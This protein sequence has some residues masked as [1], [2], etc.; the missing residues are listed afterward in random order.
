[1]LIRPGNTK[2]GEV[3]CFSLL[4]LETCPGSTEICRA[5]C[6]A[7]KRFFKMG[8]VRRAHRRNWEASQESDF[9]SKMIDEIR[10]MEL[11]LLR[12][13]V[14]GDF[15]DEEYV[16]KWIKIAKACPEVS[17]YTYTRSWREQELV[18][19][20]MQLSMVKN[21]TLW[22]S[23]D[24]ETDAID[25][26]PPVVPGIRVAYMQAEHGE[27]IPEY[28]DLVFRV[29]RDTIEK[30]VDGHMVCPAE[31]GIKPKTHCDQ[32]AM[33]WTDKPIPK[34]K[35]AKVLPVLS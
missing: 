16:R 27:L 5:S 14:A 7:T 3:P 29:K 32:C 11:E 19:A 1:M 18:P 31:N 2:L 12:V 13:H 17:F 35:T 24:K 30:F 34:R 9:V 8:N 20:L 33:C 15:Y 21:F 23:C 6:Y 25:G 10:Q 28:T 22:W 4:A 26:R